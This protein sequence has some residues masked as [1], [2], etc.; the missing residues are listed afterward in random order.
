MH[1]CGPKNHVDK[2]LHV[3]AK[4]IQPQNLPHKKLQRISGVCSKAFTGDKVSVL[5]QL[6]PPHQRQG[7]H[8]RDWSFH[9][10]QHRRPQTSLHCL[11]SVDVKSIILRNNPGEN[12]QEKNSYRSGAHLFTIFFAGYKFIGSQVWLP[13]AL[14]FSN[15]FLMQQINLKEGMETHQKLW[16]LIDNF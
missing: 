4:T 14:T 2:H 10:T 6:H 9:P 11:H 13:L 12:E 5:K 7:P 15:T 16:N 1:G 3:Y 8:L